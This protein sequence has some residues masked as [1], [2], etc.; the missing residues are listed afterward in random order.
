MGSN[1]QFQ[2]RYIKNACEQVFEIIPKD[3]QIEVVNKISCDSGPISSCLRLK[4][5]WDDT[6]WREKLLAIVLDEAH[7]IGTW[8]S[9]FRRDY[10]R[11]GELRS[12][13]PSQ[14]AFVSLSATLSKPLLD[15]VIR[16]LGYDP[17]VTQF[18]YGND[19]TNVKYVVKSLQHSLKSL[20]DLRFL[21]NFEKL[22]DSY[23]GCSSLDS[24]T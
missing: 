9:E 6:L 18:N 21:M 16:S 22:P 7:C 14:V 15:T 2:P 13:V 3:E 23:R 17:N 4:E 20:E 5:L 19:R 8:G 11:I 10:S 24:T 1:T 12:M